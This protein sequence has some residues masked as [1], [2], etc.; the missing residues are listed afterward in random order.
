MRQQRKKLGSGEPILWI[1]DQRANSLMHFCKR[2]RNFV[3]N[4]S[5]FTTNR[6]SFSEEKMLKWFKTSTANCWKKSLLWIFDD[7]SSVVYTDEIASFLNSKVL[8]LKGV[9]N[10]QLSM[11]FSNLNL[12]LIQKQKNKEKLLFSNC[13][14]QI[15]GNAQMLRK[16]ILQEPSFFKL[17]L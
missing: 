2:F 10:V 13:G 12:R 8:S 15:Q 9:K 4:N 3:S 5:E 14:A 17:Q 7:D 6:S 16:I 11:L 1:T